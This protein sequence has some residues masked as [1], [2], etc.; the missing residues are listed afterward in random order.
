[1]AS[2]VLLQVFAMVEMIRRGR[3]G[4]TYDND[5][6]REMSRHLGDYLFLYRR[7]FARVIFAVI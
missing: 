4:E 1:M 5:L 3:Q 2:Y 6:L 7:F